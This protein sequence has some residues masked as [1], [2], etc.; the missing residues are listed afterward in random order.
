MA[1]WLLRAQIAVSV[2]PWKAYAARGDEVIATSRT[3]S[4]ALG[5]VAGVT[6]HALDVSSADSVAAFVS[7]AGPVDSH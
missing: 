2:W 1:R 7:L 4:D 6:Q 3:L 5:G